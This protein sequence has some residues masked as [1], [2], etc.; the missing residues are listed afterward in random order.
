MKLEKAMQLA[1]ESAK[2]GIKQNHGG[3]FGAAIVHQNQ[4]IAVAH[5]TVLRDHD[6]TCHAEVNAIRLACKHLNTHIL[7][8]CDIYT[9]VEPCPMCLSAIYWSRLDKIFVGADK[10]IAAKYGFD[11]VVFYQEL[12]QPEANRKIACERMVY[13]SE[14]ESVFQQWRDL[15]RS[16]Y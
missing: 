15:N 7:A 6:P 16:I 4:I 3:P 11:D 13:H 1:I 12:Q 9:T 2:E 10:S 5:N 14:V 8:G